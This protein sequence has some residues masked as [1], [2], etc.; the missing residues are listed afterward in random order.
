MPMRHDACLRVTE[1]MLESVLSFR[2]VGHKDQ[3]RSLDLV[4]DMFI[5]WANLM[6]PGSVFKEKG[7]LS[8]AGWL[9]GRSATNATELE[10]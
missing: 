5:D 6:T 2:H 3:L 10:T 7:G 4:T 9:E 1:T 8:M